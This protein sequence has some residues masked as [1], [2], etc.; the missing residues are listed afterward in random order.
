LKGW[1]P[2]SGGDLGELRF[3]PADVA[4]HEFDDPVVQLGD[5]VPGG[6]ARWFNAVAAPLISASMQKVMTDWNWLTVGL[7]DR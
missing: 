1:L 3:D 4:R 5:P 2:S 6:E 7:R